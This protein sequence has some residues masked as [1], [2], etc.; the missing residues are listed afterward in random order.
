MALSSVRAWRPSVPGVAEVFHA[1]FEQF[2]Y[3][4]H[5]HAT[6]TLLLVEDGHIHYE[7]GHHDHEAD[8]RSLTLLPPHVPHNGAPGRSGGFRKKVIYLDQGELPESAIGAAVD[9][10]VLQD[11]NALRMVSRIHLALQAPGSQFEAENRLALV[12][13]RLV[14]HLTVQSPAAQPLRSELARDFREI[15]DDNT[16]SG[17][18]LRDAAALLCAHPATVVRSFGRE[19]GIA[20]HQYLMTRRVDMARDLILS[21]LP[22]AEV[23]PACGFYDQAHLG[24]SFKKVLGVTPGRYARSAGAASA[25]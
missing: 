11:D 13:E 10:P 16:V 5:S 1:R 24:R 17:I 6:W 14:H 4:M 12:K 2:S 15:L 9:R 21:G 8:P 7:L 3:P 19:F 18:T 23:A 20:P 25:P 22:L